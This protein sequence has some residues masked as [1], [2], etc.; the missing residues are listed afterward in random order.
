[1]ASVGLDVREMWS[2]LNEDL[3]GLVEYV[4]VDK[5]EW[6]P[7]P[8]LWN[9]LGIMLHIEYARSI[10]FASATQSD[11]PPPAILKTARSIS[12]IQEAYRQTWKTIKAFL[13]DAANLDAEYPGE[14]SG[15]RVV[16]HLLEHDIHHRADIFHYLALLGIEHPNVGTP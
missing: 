15:H 9:F 16:F 13:D 1:M 2:S 4:P 14:G 3:I 6:S 11:A 7:R 12:D 10:W 8:E 5:I